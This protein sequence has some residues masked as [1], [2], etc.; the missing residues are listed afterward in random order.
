MRNRTDQ[1][2]VHGY[3]RVTLIGRGNA[4][5]PELA[6]ARLPRERDR[7]T[8]IVAADPPLDLP[9]LTALLSHHLP[10]RCASIRLVL[11]EAG[12]VGIAQVIADELRIEVVAPS[13]PVMLLPTGM[14]F[15]T[16]GEWW[17]FRPG[18]AGERQGARQPAPDWERLL[19]LHPRVLPPE[20]RATAVPAGLWLH[21]A[22]PSVPPLTAALLSLPVDPERPTVVI[23]RP[24]GVPLPPEPVH[25]MLEALPRA[26]R[27]RML[28][29]PY[30]AEGGTAHTVGEWLAAR[31]GGT[32][33]VAGGVSELGGGADGGSPPLDSDERR[34]WRPFARRLV[35]RAGA[36]P[37]VTQ[38]RDALAGPPGTAGVQR[39]DAHWALEVI[40]SGLWLRSAD[41]ESEQDV[42]RRLPI[43]DRHPL[44]VLG[45][46]A[47][48]RP[49]RALAVLET[50]L[51]RLPVD[52]TGVLRLAVTRPPAEADVALWGPLVE[53]YGPLLAVVGPGHLVELPGRPFAEPEPEPEPDPEPTP[54]PATE[55]PS[56]TEVE[57]QDDVPARPGID[58]ARYTGA[59]FADWRFE[60]LPDW[61]PGQELHTPEALTGTT[62][63][64]PPARSEP[65]KRA[66]ADPVV[67]IWS[68]TGRRVTDTG[69]PAGEQ[70]RF[71]PGSRVRVVEVERHGHDEP[72]LVL[73]RDTTAEPAYDAPEPSHDAVPD[74]RVRSALRRA[75]EAVRRTPETS[76]WPFSPGRGYRVSR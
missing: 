2:R 30:G 58:G 13:G 43:D 67:V 35:Y 1:P 48:A 41:D 4:M 23:G 26:L 16:A 22:E 61:E 62:A 8:V 54:E 33:E 46:A 56:A 38:W 76:T 60:P 74:R 53:R 27:R 47:V 29:V 21:D 18:E 70:V 71:A 72:V 17:R 66:P 32:I 52:T 63:P 59:V 39:V 68:V 5:P 19:P 20:V 34:R 73:L 45:A 40:R 6:P 64:R 24:G 44:L 9:T 14:L 50:V 10:V 31:S 7:H 3:D 42:I 65:D 12:R 25:A 11:S 15:V 57:R 75:V 55:P 49:H 69:P 37:Q 51:D 36:T 28:L